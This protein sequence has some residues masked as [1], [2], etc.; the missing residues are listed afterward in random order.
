MLFFHTLARQRAAIPTICLQIKKYLCNCLSVKNTVHIPR[1]NIFIFHQMFSPYVVC[2][3]IWDSLF[4]GAYTLPLLL[5]SLGN[6]WLCV[7]TATIRLS[8]LHLLQHGDWPVHMGSF[9]LAL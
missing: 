6:D 7:Y 3:T 9:Q 1:Y 8:L 2:S 5:A 4:W